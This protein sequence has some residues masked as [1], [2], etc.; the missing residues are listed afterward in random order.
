MSKKQSAKERNAAHLKMLS[1]RVMTLVLAGRSCADISRLLKINMFTVNKIT[2]DE[3]FRADLD[4]YLIA[5]KRS[6]MDMLTSSV[7]Q[8]ARVMVENLRTRKGPNPAAEHRMSAKEILDRAGLQAVTK[9]AN[10][11]PDGTENDNAIAAL[12]NAINGVAANLA[13]DKDPSDTD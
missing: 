6:A 4:G 5:M 11:T 9:I 7:E 2:G 12:A 13:T 10:T 1:A 8:A 3:N